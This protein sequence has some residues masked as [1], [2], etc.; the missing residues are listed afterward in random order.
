MKHQVNMEKTINEYNS[1]FSDN[2]FFPIQKIYSSPHFLT[3][4]IRFQGKTRYLYVGRGGKYCGLSLNDQALPSFLRIK[5]RALDYFRKYFIGIKVGSLSLEN[6][7]LRIKIRTEGKSFEWRMAY[8]DHKLLF[9][10]NLN[11]LWVSTGNLITD[12]N[13]E[14][15]ELDQLVEIDIVKYLKDQAEKSGGIVFISKRKKFLD[16]KIANIESDLEKATKWREVKEQID[17]GKINLNEKIFKCAAFEIKFKSENEFQKI[18]LIYQKIK[19]LKKAEKVLSERLIE[20]NQELQKLKSGKIELAITKE[21]PILIHWFDEDK[22]KKKAV[23][24]SDEK[25]IKKIKI[26]KIEGVIGLNA[27]GNDQIRKTMKKDF[28]WMHIEGYPGAHCILKIDSFDQLTPEK[29][30]YLGSMLRDQSDLKLLEIQL[31]F[32]ILKNVSGIKGKKGQVLIKKPRY[33]KVNYQ[34]WKEIISFN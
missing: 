23:N 15:N 30:A 20:T 5:E 26:D 9:A 22:G 2:E 16:K 33:L 12:M 14:K 8:S 34:N 4:Q 13:Q 32:C 25:N 31:V 29:F 7:V 18:D 10:H 11:N 28:I 17:L 1:Y 3:F 24:S 27:E 19:K 6:N 21:P